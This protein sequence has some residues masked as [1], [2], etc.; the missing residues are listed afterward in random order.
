M[1]LLDKVLQEWLIKNNFDVTIQFG[2]DF[3]Y[4]I[5]DNIINYNY[6]IDE[7]FVSIYEDFL[8]E[9]GLQYNISYFLMA[10]LHELG[11][12]QTI[13]LMDDSDWFEYKAIN[14]KILFTNLDY[15]EKTKIYINSTI[16][17]EATS[18]AVNYAN[19]H[20]EELN[21]LWNRIQPILLLETFNSILE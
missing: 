19:N 14:F 21:E 17:K 18:W 16:E 3:N 10:F 7:D 4:N 5:E 20:F 8:N 15:F 6:T 11:H 1:N 9:L 2:N 13:D 12:E